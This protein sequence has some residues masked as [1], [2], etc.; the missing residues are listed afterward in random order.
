MTKERVY[1]DSVRPN[2][3]ESTNER[4]NVVVRWFHCDA[5]R[6]VYDGLLLPLGWEQWDTDQDAWYFGVWV[7]KEL[8]QTFTYAE[9]DCV[10]VFCEDATSFRA[11]ILDAERVYGKAPPMAIA[12]DRDGT[13]T[14]YYDNRLKPGEIK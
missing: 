10:Q 2:Q 12:Y 13:R 4:G 14:E 1:A 3:S 7:H 5:N 11:E 6:Y 8:R 9:G